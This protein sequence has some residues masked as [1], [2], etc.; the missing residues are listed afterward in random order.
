MKGTTIECPHCNRF[1]SVPESAFGKSLPCP[2]CRWPIAIPHPDVPPPSEIILERQQDIVAGYYQRLDELNE[3]A[4]VF[5]RAISERRT[6][7]ESEINDF[8]EGDRQRILYLIKNAKIQ[9]KA[10][11]DAAEKIADR[12]KFETRFPKKHTCPYCRKTVRYKDR[13][14]G[15]SLRCPNR[16]CGRSIP[17]P[18]FLE[19]SSL[20]TI[21]EPKGETHE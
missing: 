6:A 16:K 19:S 5:G 7:T 4:R 3:S 17:L 1:L 9:A 20:T 10:I 2:G 11:I 8:V 13:G 18:S 15:M 21:Y 12:I 14:A